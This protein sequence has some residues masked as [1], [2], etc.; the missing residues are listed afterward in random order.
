MFASFLAMKFRN[1][2][3]DFSNFTAGILSRQHKNTL[4]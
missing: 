2:S 4:V 3:E 1:Q